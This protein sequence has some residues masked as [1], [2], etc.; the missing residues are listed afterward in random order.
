MTALISTTVTKGTILPDGKVF[1]EKL[2]PA[3]ISRV[4]MSTSDFPFATIK[5][6]CLYLKSCV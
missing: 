1:V 6:A 2:R 3:T 5:G 4:R